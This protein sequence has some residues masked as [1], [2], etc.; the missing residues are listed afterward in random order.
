MKDLIKKI[1]FFSVQIVLVLLFGLVLFPSNIKTYI[2]FL[3][4]LIVVIKAFINKTKINKSLFFINSVIYVFVIFT[5][6]YSDNK[7]NAFFLLQTMSSL[8]VFPL[9]FSLLNQS[10]KEYIIKNTKNYLWVYIISITLFNTVPFLW[11]LITQDTLIEIITHYPRAII[12]DFGKYTIHPIYTAMHCSI[13]ILF[14]GYLLKNNYNKVQKILLYFLI[15]LFILFLIIYTKK[16]PILSLIIT[17]LVWTM[18]DI[19]SNIKN[20]MFYVLGFVVLIL[21]TP[22]IRTKFIELV[23][24]EKATSS[25]NATSTNIRY[26][27][28]SNSLD[29]ISES[30]LFGYGIGD[31][32]DQ[33]IKKYKE[34]STFLLDKNYNSHN[35]YLSFVLMGGFGLLFIFLFF[36]YKNLFISYQK[37]NNILIILL[38]FYGTMMLFENILERENGVIFFSLFVNFFSL[39][40]YLRIEE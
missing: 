27:I 26:S 11:Y 1:N 33:L 24:F 34:N 25:L 29:L 19:K 17:I 15:I 38:V 36:Y 3:F 30:P 20:N 13:A 18:L 4:S 5:F 9:I 22:K 7:K 2:I 16:G 8:I 40:N 12:I 32:N 39:K 28:Y 6:F 10:D 35:Q 21:L 23:S 37:N 14:S 31:V